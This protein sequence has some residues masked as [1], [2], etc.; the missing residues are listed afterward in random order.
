MK[1]IETNVDKYK[2]IIGKPKKKFV[3]NKPD[4]D[5]MNSLSLETQKIIND[6]KEIKIINTKYKYPNALYEKYKVN[7]IVYVNNEAD[8][9]FK[10]CEPT[11]IEWCNNMGYILSVIRKENNLS[12]HI[13]W[14][15]ID[16]LREVVNKGYYDIVAIVDADIIINNVGMDLTS[17]IKDGKSIYASSDGENGNSVINTGFMFVLCNEESKKFLDN[18][19]K[20]RNGKYAN[21]AYHEQTVISEMY[22]SGYY[23][24]IEVL[25]M[26][27]I[28]SFYLDDKYN[29][30]NNNVYHF[31]ARPT[32][33]KVY[34]AKSHFDIKD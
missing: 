27:E 13:T 19:W 22:R 16:L 9:Y 4:V 15:K 28:N 32:E 31:M 21:K 34:Y 33:H 5:S 7:I 1:K 3:P 25:D 30:P 14:K 11:F 26:R 6:T 12:S 18:V 24:I 17:Y 20:Q 2:K 8:Q 29:R 10:Y 23:N